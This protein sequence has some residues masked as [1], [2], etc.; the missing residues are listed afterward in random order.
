MPGAPLRSVPTGLDVPTGPP[1]D[2]PAGEELHG[3]STSPD[4]IPDLNTDRD[5]DLDDDLDAELELVFG[6]TAVVV[7]ASLLDF[8]R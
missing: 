2:S 3:A 4:L 1:S 7:A 5:D 6:P 8:L